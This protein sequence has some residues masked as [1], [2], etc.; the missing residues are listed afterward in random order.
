MECESEQPAQLWAKQFWPNI[1]ANS[2]EEA[3]PLNCVLGHEEGQSCFLWAAQLYCFI[4][5]LVGSICRRHLGA[6]GS[7]LYW[8]CPQ[9]TSCS[10]LMFLQPSP[11]LL[12]LRLLFSPWEAATKECNVASR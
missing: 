10:L 3:L 9:P 6:D 11:S 1:W 12:K 8:F 2:A 4:T 7:L 5:G